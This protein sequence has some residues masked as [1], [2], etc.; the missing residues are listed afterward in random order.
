M[1]RSCFVS[2]CHHEK[3]PAW[4]TGGEPAESPRHTRCSLLESLEIVHP[5]KRSAC[6]HASLP[7]PAFSPSREPYFIFP[8]SMYSLDPTAAYT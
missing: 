5:D 6:I 3:H 2:A 4:V 1:R 8:V 7:L